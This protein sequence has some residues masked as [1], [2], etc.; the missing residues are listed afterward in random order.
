[1]KKIRMMLLCL[2]VAL[3]AAGCAGGGAL[4]DT[5]WID[6]SAA[7]ISDEITSG[8]FVIDDVV[9]KFP[10]PLEDWLDNGWH[11][12]NNYDNVD[13]FLLEAGYTSNEFELFNEEDAYVRVSVYNDSYEAASVEDCMVY[14]LYMSTTEVDVVFPQG[15]TKR[16]KPADVLEAYGEPDA[17]GDEQSYLEATYIFDDTAM[18]QCYV[19][20]GVVD[21]DYTIHPFT[22]VNYGIASFDSYWESL[23]RNEG[24]DGAC[25]VYFDATMKASFYGDFEDYTGYAIDSE[26][27]ATE[28]YDSEVSYFAEC[29]PYSMDINLDY[30]SDEDWNKMLQI[31]KEV[32]A[33][34]KW[35][36]KNVE[37]NAFDQG[38]MTL[39]LYPTNF[40]DV[41]YDD[42]LAASDAFYTKYADADFESMSDEEYSAVEVEYTAMMLEV[43]EKHV[44]AA[45]TLDA[46]EKTYEIDLNNGVISQEDWVDIDDTIMNLMEE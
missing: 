13:E 12:S 36:V 21:N 6:E 38:T 35:E 37:V 42:A 2:T 40:F 33:K 8:E 41:I 23:V 7:K 5:K 16:N 4:E 24:E 27:G 28:L 22:S 25:K 45:G 30:I 15:M 26:A 32:L 9:Y 17:R 10:M 29:L 3:M 18:G 39:A 44:S 20:L 46:V 14:S 11:I 19:E 31:S 34:T 43:F 1:M